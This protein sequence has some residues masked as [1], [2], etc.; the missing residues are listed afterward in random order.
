MHKEHLKILLK[1][2]IF[3]LHPQDPDLMKWKK[4]GLATNSD[5]K[6]YEAQYW[7]WEWLESQTPLAELSGLNTYGC[8]HPTK[9]DPKRSHC[10]WMNTLV[11]VFL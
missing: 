11:H 7:S 2:F 8:G 10:K 6:I 9:K 4:L 5:L 3:E 1:I